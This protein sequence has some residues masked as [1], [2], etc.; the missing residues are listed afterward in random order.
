MLTISSKGGTIAD[1]I[2]HA[3]DFHGGRVPYAAATALTAVANK[4]AKQDIPNAMRQVFDRPTPYTL[5]SLRTWGKADK[6]NLQISVGVKESASNNGVPAEN[7][8][9]PH[10]FG[11]ERKN[12]KFENALRYA[13][14][15]RG[16]QHITICESSE[17]VDAFGNLP[18]KFVAQLISYFQASTEQGYSAN[19]KQENINRMAKR[20]IS[21]TGYKKINGVVYFAINDPK[22]HLRPGIYSKRGTHGVDI[23]PV[24][25]F[26]DKTPKY[27]Q[28]FDFHG[29]AKKC[30]EDNFAPEFY[31]ALDNLMNKGW[32]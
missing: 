4:A 7:F 24:V 10:V 30:A 8:V 20:G 18:G 32:K 5:G 12:K 3:R 23:R 9:Y 13:G 14:I 27:Q 11:G 1:V 17:H 15:L 21:K 25:W 26:V 19:M 31:K 22:S 6:N 29:I 16:N 2:A 28:R